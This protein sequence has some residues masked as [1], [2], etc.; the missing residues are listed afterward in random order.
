MEKRQDLK[1]LIACQREGKG[2]Y[3][4]EKELQRK[5][6]I[7]HPHLHYMSVF[8]SRDIYHPKKF[9]QKY[10]TTLFFAA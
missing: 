2:E 7:L 10:T 8:R 4:F 1:T 9:L 6:C 5:I 3:K